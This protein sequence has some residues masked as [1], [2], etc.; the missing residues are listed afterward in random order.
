MP[1]ATDSS[2]TGAAPQHGVEHK[3]KLR[4]KG[5]SAG[6]LAR[7]GAVGFLALTVLHGL[8]TGGHL[9]DPRN[10][11]YGL[12]G[13]VAGYFGYAAR[14][15]AIAGLEHQSPEAVLSVI[16]VRPDASLLLFDAARAKRILENVDWVEH[17]SV[18]RVHPNKL[19]IEVTERQPYA[20]WQRGGAYYVIDRS[21]IALS[22]LEARKYRKLMLVTGE[23]AN[24]AVFELVNHLEETGALHSRVRAAAR[25]G[26]RRWTLYLKNG[27]RIALPEKGIGNALA[28]LLALHG[29]TGVLDKAVRLVDLRLDDR[30]AV[31]IEKGEP[32]DVSSLLVSSTR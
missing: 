28:K 22:T 6:L 25:V 4:R 20:V 23:G 3:G 30:I 16:G 7:A 31:A 32:E 12:T 29:Q 19:E 8:E 1:P 10:P 5:L 11:L 18:R 13:N 15:I 24:E 2:G 27:V 26:G 17:A 14:D 21:G 9:N